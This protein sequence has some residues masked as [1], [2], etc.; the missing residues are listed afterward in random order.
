MIIKNRLRWQPSPS[1]SGMQALWQSPCP[2][3]YFSCTHIRKSIF[4]RISI[5]LPSLF[6]KLYVY[7]F[8]IVQPCYSELPFITSS[9]FFSN[10]R[11]A[12]YPSS[13]EKYTF[14]DLHHFIHNFRDLLVPLSPYRS[15]DHM[16]RT[17]G[18]NMHLCLFMYL[19]LNPPA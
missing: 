5:Y 10:L 1:V 2:F 7:R 6:P 15:T 11:K 3:Q 8:I 19:Q 13:L 12:M 4:N 9:N 16:W 18:T 17:S 14:A